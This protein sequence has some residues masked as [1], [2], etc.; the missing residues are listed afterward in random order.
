MAVQLVTYALERQWVTRKRCRHFGLWQ[1]SSAPMRSATSHQGSVSKTKGHRKEYFLLGGHSIGS[2]NNPCS[3]G[4][5]R[6]CVPGAKYQ[7]FGLCWRGGG[8]S[9]V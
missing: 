3:V 2:C 1:I 4:L 6:S 9:D 8:Q 7:V 5:A